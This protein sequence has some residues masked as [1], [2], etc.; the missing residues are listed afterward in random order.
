MSDVNIPIGLSISPSGYF[1]DERKERALVRRL[2]PQ[3]TG[4]LW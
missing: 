2:M 3:L 4:R 1:F